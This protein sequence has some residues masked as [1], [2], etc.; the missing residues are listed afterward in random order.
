MVSI[1]WYPIDEN[2]EERDEYSDTGEEQHYP[3]T[4]TT[5][6]QYWIPIIS[7]RLMTK[8]PDV[9]VCV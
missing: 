5:I 4:S 3:L 7:Y 1:T 9:C 6:P 8:W 2:S